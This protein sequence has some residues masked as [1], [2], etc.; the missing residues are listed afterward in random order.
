MRR[1]HWS[2]LAAL[3][4]ASLIGEFFFIGEHDQ[5]WWNVIPGFYIIFGF[6]GCLLIIFLSKAYG[7]LLVQRKKNYYLDEYDA[8]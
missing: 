5:H 2:V 7:K 8:Q 3:T 4:I 1:M 6:I